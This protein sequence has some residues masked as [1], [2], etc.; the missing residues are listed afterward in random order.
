MRWR[1]RQ[2]ERL[3]LLSLLVPNTGL[4]MGFVRSIFLDPLGLN[5]I[6]RSATYLCNQGTSSA[7]TI[8]RIF[9]IVNDCFRQVKKDVYLRGKT[10]LCH[11]KNKSSVTWSVKRY[12]FINRGSVP[13]GQQGE[14]INSRQ[15][16][17]KGTL[18]KFLLT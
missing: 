2:Y 12:L 6:W 7:K 17:F 18:N 16:N 13:A 1:K 10:L 5:Q 3:S 8:T 11:L 15:L 14:L 9:A 4:Q